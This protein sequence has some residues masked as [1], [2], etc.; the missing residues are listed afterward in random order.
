MRQIILDLLRF[1]ATIPPPWHNIYTLSTQYLHTIYT[2]STHYL[3]RA[4]LLEY[5]GKIVNTAANLLAILAAL[6]GTTQIQHLA[7]KAPP[8]FTL[9]VYKTLKSLGSKDVQIASW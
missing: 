8:A 1:S 5:A 2:I 9:T 6:L 4:A 7:D 3:H